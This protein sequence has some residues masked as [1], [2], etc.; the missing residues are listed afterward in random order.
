MFPIGAAILEDRFRI[1]I[2]G[3]PDS[4]AARGDAD[5]ALPPGMCMVSFV[6]DS[7]SDLPV[8]AACTTTG[9]GGPLY[10]DGRVARINGPDGEWL[11]LIEAPAP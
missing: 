5:G 4:A 3:Y 1:E 7:L 6:V 10:G 8:T 9:L 11:E 2:D